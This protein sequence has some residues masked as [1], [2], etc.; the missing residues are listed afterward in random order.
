MAGSFGWLHTSAPTP[1]WPRATLAH[2]RASAAYSPAW[3]AIRTDPGT[4]TVALLGPRRAILGYLNLTPRQGGETMANW[5]VFRLHH[6]A[7]EG[8]RA[9]LKEASA[10]G[11]VFP[12]GARGSCVVDRYAT[13]TTRYREIA[14]LAGAGRRTTVVVAA[15]PLGEWATQASTLRREIAS[16]R[17]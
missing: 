5:A 3:A 6:N 1:G 15:A 10:R 12:S 9:V 2:G 14:C 16:L 13:S 17:V 8:D 7:K 11:L 4:A